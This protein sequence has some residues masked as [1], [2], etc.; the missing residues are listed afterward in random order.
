MEISVIIPTFAPGNY[1]FDCFD[2][3]KNQTFDKANFE[4]IIV[5]NGPKYPFYNL[6]QGYIETS[7][8]LNIHLLYTEINGVSNARNLAL[9]HIH[10][11]Y[12]IFID[13]DDIVSTNYLEALYKKANN[14]IIAVSNVRTFR[15][16]LNILGD[17]YISK[18]FR[19][20]KYDQKYNVFKYRRFLSNVWGKIIPEKVIGENRFNCNFKIGE[21]C[22]FIFSISHRITK[23]ALCEEDVIYYRRLRDGSAT[24]STSGINAIIR[25]AYNSINAY[26][27]I[28]FGNPLQYDLFF[29]FSRLLA[30]I[31]EVFIRIKL[32]NKS[33]IRNRP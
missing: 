9:D 3:I 11:K 32:R 30:I 24:R 29:Y 13:D 4:V 14:N 18:C 10:S 7:K 22:L 19:K 23:I 12:V 15:D 28:Y 20:L 21:D 27:K 2:S 33:S 25:N 31:L 5:L 1:I 17:D 26:T 6:L 16:D 8:T